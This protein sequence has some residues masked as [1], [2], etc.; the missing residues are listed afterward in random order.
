TTDWLMSYPAE[1][2]ATGRTCAQSAVLPGDAIS[3][4]RYFYDG[5]TTFDTAPAKG[6]R[7]RTDVVDSYS[8][9]TAHWQTT[10]LTTYDALG[11]PAAVTDPRLAPGIPA[12]RVTRTDYP[13]DTGPLTQTVVTN[14]LGW[15]T[16]TTYNPAWGA[17][18]A[19]TDVNNHKTEVAYDALG[20]RI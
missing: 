11:R 5:S 8:G 20:R 14:P 2:S 3:D 17:E 7:T 6:N 18:T 16:T 13:P 1:E 9:T 10:T 15:T 19:V 4:T 12:A